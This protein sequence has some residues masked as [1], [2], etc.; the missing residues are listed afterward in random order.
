MLHIVSHRIVNFFVSFRIWGWKRGTSVPFVSSHILLAC[1]IHCNFLDHRRDI[2]RKTTCQH[3]DFFEKLLNFRPRL[4]NLLSF[5]RCNFLGDSILVCSWKTI[6]SCCCL[7]YNFWFWHSPNSLGKKKPLATID[8]SCW[9]A[10]CF[11]WIIILIIDQ[12][13]E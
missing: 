4:E 11:F 5:A 1:S 10:Q 3:R 7:I 8:K 2:S 9:N 12:T 6:P 13:V